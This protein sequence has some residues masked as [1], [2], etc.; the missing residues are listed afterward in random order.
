M[1]EN[2]LQKLD[3]KE[4]LL[5]LSNYTQT[6]EAKDKCLSLTPQFNKNQVEKRWKL[7]DFFKRTSS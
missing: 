2:T 1:Q 7:V 6:P 5:T 4:L 3:W